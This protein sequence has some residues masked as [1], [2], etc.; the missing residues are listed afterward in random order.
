MIYHVYRGDGFVSWH[1]SRAA[2]ERTAAKYARRTG[3]EH[4]VY[5]VPPCGYT[6]D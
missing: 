4:W 5:Q 6:G 2:A 1:R 3:L